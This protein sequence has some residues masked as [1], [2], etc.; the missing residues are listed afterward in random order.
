ML[1]RTKFKHLMYVDQTR[2]IVSIIC[3]TL[4]AGFQ[5]LV[6]KRL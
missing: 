5:F 4:T 2:Q 1:I 3:R 6:L